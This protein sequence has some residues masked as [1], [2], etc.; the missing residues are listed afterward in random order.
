[1]SNLDRIAYLR[2]PGTHQDCQNLPV[3]IQAHLYSIKFVWQCFV[4]WKF[5]YRVKNSLCKHR[6]KTYHCVIKL[7][8]GFIQ[9]NLIQTHKMEIKDS[10]LQVTVTESSLIFFFNLKR[11]LWEDVLEN[12]SVK[13][14]LVE[15]Q[16]LMILTIALGAPRYWY[17]IHKRKIQYTCT[18]IC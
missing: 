10:G 9:L 12:W 13:L 2:V 18:Y 7:Y 15:A 3:F 11:L 8:L 17:C 4:I 14:P 6:G 16:W 1:M 5:S